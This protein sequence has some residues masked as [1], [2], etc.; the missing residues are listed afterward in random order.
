MRDELRARAASLLRAERSAEA[1]PAADERKAT[2]CGA[3]GAEPPQSARFCPQC[4][5]PL[6][7]GPGA[8]A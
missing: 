6:A 7:D 2:S 5:A 3:C 8:A 4:G 1:A